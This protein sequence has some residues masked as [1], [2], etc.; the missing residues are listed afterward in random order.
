LKQHPLSAAFPAMSDDDFQALKDDIEANGQRDPIVVLDGMVLDGWHRFQ[1]CTA[2]LLD[3]VLA[4]FPEDEDPVAFVKSKNLQRRHLTAAQRVAAVAA[5]CEWSPP[6]RPERAAADKWGTG[7]PLMTNQQIADEA[8]A[9][10]KTVKW[11][12]AGMRAGLTEEI[13]EGKVSAKRAAEIAKLPE[14]ERKTA[15]ESPAARETRRDD[16]DGECTSPATVQ[17]AASLEEAYEDLDPLAERQELLNDIERLN[18][19]IRAMSADDQ[20]AELL[21]WKLLYEDALRKQGEAQNKIKR[22]EAE[23]QT[24]S[25]RLRRIGKLFNERDESKIPPLV[26]KFVRQH[27]EAA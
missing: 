24:A 17:H 2:L 14:S 4:E 23:I 20:K 10:V 15:V 9:S 22:L 12:K 13:K 8:G 26:E 5:C 6:H 16:E 18:A 1:A 3:P 21:K 19:Q 7:S 27:R 25:S 11:V